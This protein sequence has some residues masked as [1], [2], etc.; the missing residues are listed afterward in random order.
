MLFYSNVRVSDERRTRDIGRDARQQAPECKKSLCFGVFFR[1]KNS[2]S[3][4]VICIDIL[5]NMYYIIITDAAATAAVEKGLTPEEWKKW[6]ESFFGSIF[7][8]MVLDHEDVKEAV[9]NEIA[10]K[11]YEELRQA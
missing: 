6:K 10:P 8:K 11:I 4:C 3:Y 2:S 7:F 5:R 1:V 9:I